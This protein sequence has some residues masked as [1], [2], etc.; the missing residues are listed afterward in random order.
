MRCYPA[1]NVLDLLPCKHFMSLSRA[2]SFEN[3]GSGR[4][5]AAMKRPLHSMLSRRERE[6]MD[7]LYRTGV[8][9]AH[10]IR[11]AQSA[12]PSHST[13]R[14][15]LRVLERKGYIRRAHGDESRTDWSMALG[16]CFY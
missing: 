6:I 8:A 5:R 3:T 9:S 12:S 10:A 14:T 13:V 7:V 1:R 4:P 16:H 2:C 15:Q 11:K